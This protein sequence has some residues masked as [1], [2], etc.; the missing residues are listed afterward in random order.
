M[1]R[2]FGA[3]DLMQLT[4]QGPL[5]PGV[6]PDERSAP[7]VHIGHVIDGLDGRFGLHDLRRQQRSILSLDRYPT[8]E[9]QVEYALPGFQCERYLAVDARQIEPL[10]HDEVKVALG[11]DQ[12]FLRSRP[13]HRNDA[14]SVGPDRSVTK[15][16]GFGHGGRRRR[17]SRGGRGDN[18]PIIVPLTKA[19]DDV[20]TL[21]AERN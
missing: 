6:T 2:V 17:C 13:R 18:G 7:A 20:W 9:R 21:P 12:K 3:M 10:G 8:M 4:V 1:Q 19:A 5:Q 14:F 15:R 11:G 16:P